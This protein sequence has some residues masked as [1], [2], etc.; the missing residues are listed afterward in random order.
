MPPQQGQALGPLS[1]RHLPNARAGALRAEGE[2]RMPDLTF[3]LAEWRDEAMLLS[4]R[5]DPE[6][7]ANC[8]TRVG[9]PPEEHHAWMRARMEENGCCDEVPRLWIAEA[10]GVPLGVVR[11]RLRGNIDFT[12]APEHRRKGVGTALVRFALEHGG[13]LM[14]ILPHNTASLRIAE[15]CWLAVQFIR[16]LK[17]E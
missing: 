13:L 4:W 6:T 5:N 14:D 15:K 1:L 9:G 16:Y 17:R 12:V 10:D 3:R 8:L 7:I 2:A 11:V